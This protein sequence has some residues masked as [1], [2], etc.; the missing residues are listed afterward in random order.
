MGD[1]EVPNELMMWVELALGVIFTIL[2]LKSTFNI[3]NKGDNHDYLKRY[4]CLS[5]V[6][7]IRLFVFAI[8][9]VFV[10]L[11]TSHIFERLNV[12]KP[13]GL[14]YIFDLGITISLGIAYYFILTN[15]FKRVNQI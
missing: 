4:T 14:D 7:I 2:T 1:D 15:S 3:N 8:P 9:V 10:S 6:A 11:L 12:V 5:L 13:G